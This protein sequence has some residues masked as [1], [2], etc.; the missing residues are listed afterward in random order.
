MQQGKL[1]VYIY[2]NFTDMVIST[3]GPAVQRNL[4]AVANNLSRQPWHY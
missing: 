4:P 2:I 1:C 3:Y